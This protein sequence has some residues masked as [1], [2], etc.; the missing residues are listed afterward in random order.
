MHK[1]AGK[2]KS[3]GSVFGEDVRNA[4]DIV[5]GVLPVLMGLGAIALV[6]AEYA[7]LFSFLGQPFMPF[8][9]QK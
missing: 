1:K 2:V 3:F 8:L 5:F 7:S 9:L 6:I 4:I